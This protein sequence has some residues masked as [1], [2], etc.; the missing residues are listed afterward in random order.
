MNKTILLICLALAIVLAAFFCGL[1]AYA[2]RVSL[3]E[4]GCIVLLYH[5]L[6]APSELSDKD[7]PWAVCSTDFY[8]QLRYLK[9]QGVQ[10]ITVE[11]LERFV[12]GKDKR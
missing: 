2:D 3:A 9:E 5:K 8:R 6:T 12:A 7:D 10:F 1:T 4:E 11:D